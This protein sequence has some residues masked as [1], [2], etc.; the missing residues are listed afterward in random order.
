MNCYV[1]VMVYRILI[2]KPSPG[3]SA[4]QAISLLLKKGVPESNIIFLNLISVSHST[5]GASHLSSLLFIS[6]VSILIFF[7]CHEYME[8]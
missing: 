3:N 8:F 2:L 6:L 5:P 1:S 4:V 7:T